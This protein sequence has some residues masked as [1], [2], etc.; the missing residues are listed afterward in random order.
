M[1]PGMDRTTR[2]RNKYSRSCRQRCA[3]AMGRVEKR[4]PI[5][6]SASERDN[7]V[8]IFPN[9]G[10]AGA[11]A[12]LGFL[13]VFGFTPSLA[14]PFGSTRETAFPCFIEDFRLFVTCRSAFP[15]DFSVCL[16]DDFRPVR[17]LIA[18]GGASERSDELS[19]RNGEES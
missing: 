8:S 14:L 7:L 16:P 1:R 19:K 12:D 4:T 18:T 10:A 13:V 5:R 6:S 11:G 17:D 2:K 9:T 3:R 15:G